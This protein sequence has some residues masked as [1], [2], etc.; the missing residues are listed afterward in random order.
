MSLEQIAEV[1]KSHPENRMAKHFDVEYYNSLETDEKK[2]QLLLCCKSGAENADSGMGLYAM[3]PGDYD[4]FKPYFDKVR[5][6]NRLI[7]YLLCR[8]R[9]CVCCRSLLFFIYKIV[10]RG[11]ENLKESL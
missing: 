1:A 6:A 9:S 11:R 2:A 3:A 7:P 8:R 4:D 5:P 10:Y